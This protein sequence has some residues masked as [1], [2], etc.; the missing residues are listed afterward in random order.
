LLGCVMVRLLGCV[1]VRLLGCVMVRLLGCVMV[2]LLGCVLVRL[3]GCVMVRLLGCVMVGL[4]GCL[5]AR[6]LGCVRRMT[7]WFLLDFAIVTS[8]VITAAIITVITAAVIT[9]ITVIIRKLLRLFL[10]GFPIA[11]LAWW[12]GF[13]FSHPRFKVPLNVDPFWVAL[14]LEENHLGH[15]DDRFRK[16]HLILFGQLQS[17]LRFLIEHEWVK[18]NENIL[19]AL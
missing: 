6:L 11:T 13:L 16:L 3:L 10:S 8:T 5:M 2:R 12:F 4:L 18:G 19:Q 9:V 14:V 7:P 17:F 15:L 1:L